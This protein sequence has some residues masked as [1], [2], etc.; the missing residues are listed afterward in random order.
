MKNFKI[1]I[2]L[3]V[4]IFITACNDNYPRINKYKLIQGPRNGVC[5]V[6]TT[7]NPNGI[8]IIDEHI[9]FYGYNSDFILLNQK[10]QDSIKNIKDLNQVERKRKTY[11]SPFNQFYILDIKRDLK[12][13]PFTKQSYIKAK[14]ELGISK[15]FKMDYSTLNFYIK[16]QRDDFNYRELDAEVID[17]NN[18]KGNSVS[19]F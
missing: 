15:D 5:L 3:L 11:A 6:D 12:Y 9:L 8:M 18:L 16:G 14:S 19:S 2:L 7:D 4:I 10:P 13:G 1:T 17:V